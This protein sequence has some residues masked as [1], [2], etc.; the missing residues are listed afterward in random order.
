M[1]SVMRAVV[2]FVIVAIAFVVFCLL[3]LR[4]A[5]VRFLP[6]WA[7]AIICVISIPLGGIVYLAVG[8]RW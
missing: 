4:K 6:K 7:W 1:F 3:D 5:E 2:P 8:R